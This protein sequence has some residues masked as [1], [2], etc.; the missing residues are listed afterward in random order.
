MAR[1]DAAMSEVRA[2]LLTDVVDSTQLSQAL[3]DEAMAAVWAAHDRVARDLLPAHRGREIDKTDGMLLM[4]DAAVDAVAYAHAYHRAIGGLAVPLKAR[5]GLH[6]GQVILRSNAADDVARG[7]KPLEVDGLAKPTAARVMSLAQGA[8]TLLTSEAMAALGESAAAFNAQSHGHWAMKGVSEPIELFEVAP[9]GQALVMPLDGEKVHHVVQVHG[10]WLAVKQIA[11]NLPQQGTPFLGREREIDEVRAAL[12]KSRLVTL[13]GMGGLGKTR[14]SLQVAAELMHEFA[15]GVWFLDLSP[16]NDPALVVTEAAQLLEVQEELGRSLLQSLCTRLKTQRVLL[17]LDNC[18][19]LVKPSAELSY[20]ILR[21][22]PGAR[23]LA[24]SREALRVPGEQTYPVLPLPV[25]RVGDG[26]AA[27]S[28]LTAVQLF[29]SRAQAHKPAFELNERE[30][31]AVAELVARLEGIPLALELAAARVRAMSVADI[32]IR[33]KDR[34]K[35]LTGGS[36][37]L[38]QR[39]QTLRALVDWSYD[40]LNAAEQTLLSRLAVFSGGFDLNA[41]EQVCG[42]DPIEDFEV[43][44]LL[45]SLV[46]KSLVMLHERETGSRYA[47]LETIR[48]YSREKLLAGGQASA[49]AARHC[50]HYFALSKNVRRGLQGPEPAVWVERMEAELDNLRAALVAAQTG[51]VDPLIAVKIPVAMLGFWILRGYCT[52]GRNAVRLALAMPEVQATELAHAH[53]LYVGAGLADCQSDHAEAQAKLEACLRLRRGLGDPLN[54]AATLSTLSLVRLAM[55]DALAARTG[56]DEA[57]DIFRQLG[58]SVGEAVGLLHLGQIGLHLGESDRA[59][60]C[61]LQSLAVARSINNREIEAESEL[62]LGQVA[63]A[64]GDT[65]NAALRFTRSLAICAEAADKKGHANAQWW[66]GKVDLQAGALASARARLV[67]A[68]LA[69]RSFE[70]HQPLLGCLDDLALLALADHQPLLAARLRAATAAARQSLQLTASQ[71]LS[72]EAMPQTPG[73]AASHM[74]S[75]DHSDDVWGIDEACR[76]AAQAQRAV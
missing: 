27:L 50:E 47:M 57:L 51:V 65:L 6:V 60:S 58:D 18:E 74:E 13:L 73:S 24:S 2:L 5:A 14:L 9:P 28:R 3:G 32:N 71:R 7:A 64:G 62:M 42:V 11:N 72:D 19:H 37:V 43:L 68:M 22:A 55:G 20:A 25:P 53:A 76:Q 35:I 56:E 40:L 17:I 38:Q 4:F 30:A 48:D 12:H 39:Q 54:I 67:D 46:E 26:V 69:L 21:A 29:V 45:S 41:A 61:L 36:R 23:V 34:Y 75:I 15:D 31:P 59:Q 66:L 8:Q 1:G 16:I 52:E 63:F 44:D 49:A 10:R 70:M 33:L